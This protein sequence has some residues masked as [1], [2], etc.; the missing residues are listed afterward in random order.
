MVLGKR[1]E[2][3]AIPPIRFHQVLSSIIKKPYFGSRNFSLGKDL[4]D[5]VTMK[6]TPRDEI[7]V[8]MRLG[9]PI[10][11]THRPG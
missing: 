11:F 4:I 5:L 2:Q 3:L 1:F 8:Q 9:G 10:V 7:L 6:N